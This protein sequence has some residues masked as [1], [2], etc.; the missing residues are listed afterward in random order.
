MSLPEGFKLNPLAPVTYQV[1]A[2]NEQAIVAAEALNSRQEAKVTGEGKV[3]F[4]L[5][6][7][8][9]TGNA[10]LL[11]KLVYNYCRDGKGGVC[12]IGSTVWKIPVSLAEDGAAGIELSVNAED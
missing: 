8:S 1:V 4:S 11:L 10:T 7:K 5:P 9:A 6:L 12:K 2:E 3:Q